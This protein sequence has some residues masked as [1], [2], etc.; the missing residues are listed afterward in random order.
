MNFSKKFL[1][2]RKTQMKRSKVDYST[3]HRQN[4]CFLTLKVLQES[5]T[6]SRSV[7]LCQVGF[8][9]QEKNEIQLTENKLVIKVFD[10]RNEKNRNAA[11]G[12]LFIHHEITALRNLRLLPLF[13][14]TYSDCGNYLYAIYPYLENGDLFSFVS[15]TQSK[16]LSEHYVK[17]VFHGMASAVQLCHENGICHRDISLENF[18]F[19]D[20]TK[21]F[22][23]LIDFGLSIQMNPTFQI[24]HTGPVGKVGYMAPELWIQPSK[25]KTYD[26]RKVDS[27]S[28]GVV[29]FILVTRMEP[30]KKADSSEAFFQKIVLEKDLKTVMNQFSCN[31]YSPLLTDLLQCILNSDPNERPCVFQ[32]L[33]HPWFSIT[34]EFLG[35]E[36]LFVKR[37]RISSN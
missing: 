22:P 31:N 14:W 35:E 36:N 13:T 12:E 6:C 2:V 3:N 28:L 11:Q 1:F 30:W 23:V 15:S 37:V 25:L 24:N 17:Q 16:T 19:G 29:L 9:H 21:S 10:I 5:K 18:L 7:E 33:Q 32:I 20:N 4:V 27:W 26:G 34:D 8:F